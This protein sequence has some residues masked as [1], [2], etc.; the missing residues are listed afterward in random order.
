MCIECICCS[1][2]AEPS[3]DNKCTVQ[4]INESALRYVVFLL[5]L[6]PSYTLLKHLLLAPHC[7]FH[8]ALLGTGTTT[9]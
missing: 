7:A 3:C 1:F 8:R 4:L 5:I 2:R 6:H 9:W